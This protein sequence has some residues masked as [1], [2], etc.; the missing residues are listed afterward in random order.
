LLPGNQAEEK[1]ECLW[2]AR[3]MLKFIQATLQTAP[4]SG[5]RTTTT[6]HLSPTKVTGV[7]LQLGSR[8]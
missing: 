4:T 3:A 8:L 5:Q 7:T 1:C 6:R 2:L